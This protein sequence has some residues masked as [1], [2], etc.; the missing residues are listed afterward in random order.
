MILAGSVLIKNAVGI[1]VV[2]ALFYMI[3]SPVLNLAVFSLL[4]KLTAALVE[5]ISDSRI[6]N[7]CVSMSK[8]VTYLTVTLLAVGFMLFVTVLLM[9]FSANAFF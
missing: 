8:T 7:F 9:I 1:A 3:L 5:P 4:L 2:V 6:A